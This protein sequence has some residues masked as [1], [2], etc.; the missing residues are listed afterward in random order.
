MRRLTITILS[1]ILGINF[2]LAQND[3]VKPY[4]SVKQLDFMI[5][6]WEGT[7]WMMTRKGKENSVVKEKAEYKL[8]KSIIVVEGIGTKTD[9]IKNNTTTIH[10]A[11]GIISYDSEKKRLLMNAYKNGESTLSEIKFIANKVIQWGMENTNGS[12]VRF[13]VDFSAKDKWTEIGEF[14][15]DGINWTKFL[16]MKLTRK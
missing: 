7:S 6:E 5:G 13:T 2:C 8:G 11:F 10:N 4:T 14:S 12:K 15:R 3:S 16:E 1:L 9:T